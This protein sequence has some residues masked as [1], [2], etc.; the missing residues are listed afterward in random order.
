VKRR[1]S[2]I[3]FRAYAFLV[4][5]FFLLWTCSDNRERLYFLGHGGWRHEWFLDFGE[6]GGVTLRHYPADLFS[7]NAP[8]WLLLI[9]LAILAWAFAERILAASRRSAAR[10]SGF[11]AEC[12]YDLRATPHRCPECGTIPKAPA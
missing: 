6:Q 2:T 8:G 4:G 5:A 7:V 12:G 3:L 11:C 9:G 10:N 1:L